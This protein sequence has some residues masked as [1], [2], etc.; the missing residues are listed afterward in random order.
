MTCSAR[1]KLSPFLVTGSHRS[2]TTWVGRLLARAPGIAY[3]D[4]PFRPDQRPGIFDPGFDR[5]FAHAPDY[6]EERIRSE[7]NRVL[8][9]KYSLSNELKSIS[10][11]RDLL[12][13]GRDAGCFIVKRIQAERVL[14]KDPIAVLSSSWIAEKFGACVVVMVRHPAA[15]TYSLKRKGWTFPFDHLLGQPRL[16]E[17]HL[18]PFKQE[19]ARFSDQSQPISAQAGLL[20]AVIYHVVSKFLDEHSDWIVVRHEDLARDP[21]GGF[22]DLYERLG[23]SYTPSC[24]RAVVEASRS[25]NPTE[26]KNKAKDIH[27]D[28]QGLIGR[29]RNGLDQ[30]KIATVREYTEQVADRWYDQSTWRRSKTGDPE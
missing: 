16:M 22:C 24:R 20:W 4:E 19:I 27:R 28:S 23:L 15:F 26:P 29:W 18:G 1:S 30:G 7:L 8:S 12:R 14:L 25:D 17:E 2:G 10:S 3:V 11:I 21:V 9:L 6:N 5:W 13:M